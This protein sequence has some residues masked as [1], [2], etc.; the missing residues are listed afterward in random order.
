MERDSMH[1][2]WKNKIPRNKFN[3]VVEGLIPENYKTLLKEI[4]NDIK[5]WKEIP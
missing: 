2:D 1:M 3:Q 5:R 4:D